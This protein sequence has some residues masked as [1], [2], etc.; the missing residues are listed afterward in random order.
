MN[1][2]KAP[3]YYKG[4][5]KEFLVDGDKLSH[6]T[7]EVNRCAGEYCK[8]TDQSRAL[9]PIVMRDYPESLNRHLSRKDVFE[10]K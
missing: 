9:M 1:D 4:L 6:I 3:E 10:S 7:V 5:L 8:R 2:P